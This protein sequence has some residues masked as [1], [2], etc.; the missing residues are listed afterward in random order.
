MRSALVSTCLMRE[1]AKSAAFGGKRGVQAS[2][3]RLGGHGHVNHA[4]HKPLA[5]YELPH[6]STY[7]T[8]QY[9]FGIDPSVPYKAEGWEHITWATYIIMFGLIFS[10]NWDMKKD[11]TFMVC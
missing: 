9:L 2:S 10:A 5:P 11:D 4:P 7:P 3:K 6:H 1:A 8:Q